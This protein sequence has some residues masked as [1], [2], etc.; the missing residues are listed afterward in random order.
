MSNKLTDIKPY[1]HNCEGRQATVKEIRKE[2]PT[3]GDHP[4]VGDI[5]TLNYWHL[6]MVKVADMTII[7]HMRKMESLT[8]DEVSKMAI[9]VDNNILFVRNVEYKSG[10]RTLYFDAIINTGEYAAAMSIDTISAAQFHYLTEIGI[11]WWATTDM[12]EKGMIIEVK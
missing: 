10:I 5:I 7:P 9:M 2:V 12:W 11:A 6:W 8:E 3:V 1:L 4:K